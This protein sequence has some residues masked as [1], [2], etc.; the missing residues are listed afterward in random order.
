MMLSTGRSLCRTAMGLATMIIISLQTPAALADS[1]QTPEMT[2]VPAGWFWQGSDAIERD[3]AYRIDEQIYGQDV[4]HRNRWYDSEI[5]KWRIYL[6]QFE[7]STTPVTNA[8]YAAFVKDAGYPAPGVTKEIWDTYGLVHGFEATRPFTWKKGL[9]PSGRENHPVVLVSWQDAV[10]YTHWLSEKTG[11][12]WRLPNEAEWEKAVRGPDGTFY[13][14]GNIYDPT[15]LNSADR[16]PFDTMPV[17]SFPAGPYGLF[18]G[19]GQVFEWTM[20]QQQP[21]ARIVKGGSWDDRGCGVCRPAARHSRPEHLR[22]I[23]IGFRVLRVSSQD[24]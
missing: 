18:D 4:A 5:T 21:G 19:A 1:I 14:W 9:P 15:L 2:V 20:T 23:L 17:K 11:D 10:A 16:G 8:Q 22:H 12:S 7:I 13:P 6:P 24:K 3:Y